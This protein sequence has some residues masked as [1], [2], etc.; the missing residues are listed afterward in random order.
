MGNFIAVIGKELN[1]AVKF[2]QKSMMQCMMHGDYVVTVY[3]PPGLQIPYVSHSLYQD[4]DL[5]QEYSIEVTPIWKQLPGQSQPTEETDEY[6]K[7][8]DI[9]KAIKHALE[10][11]LEK[12]VS[13]KKGG[14]FDPVEFPAMTASF[15][16]RSISMNDDL[17]H[18]IFGWNFVSGG[19]GKPG[20]TANSISSS[21]DKLPLL[22][23]EV[24]GME[25]VTM[26][27]YREYNVNYSFEGKSTNNLKIIMF[28]VSRAR[29]NRFKKGVM[30]FVDAGPK[31]WFSINTV[32]KLLFL[33]LGFLFLYGRLGCTEVPVKDSAPSSGMLFE[34]EPKQLTMMETYC[35]DKNYYLF[36]VAIS[37]LFLTAIKMI[38][39]KIAKKRAANRSAANAAAKAAAK[40]DD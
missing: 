15:L 6:L 12:F 40:K 35:A 24:R 23:K 11:Q 39:G 27:C 16:S 7:Q 25:G 36:T 28:R 22:T 34:E 2:Q 21:I 29:E 4:L 13:E 18:K 37:F 14:E 8:I 17:E 33:V 1:L 31:E 38:F 5:S 32:H 26:K 10:Q 30:D 9:P 3:S 19:I 20:S